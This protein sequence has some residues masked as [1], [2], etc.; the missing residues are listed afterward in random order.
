MSV[1]TNKNK[2]KQATK[3][4]GIPVP[5]WQDGI[6]PDLEM[7]KWQMVENMLMASMRGSVNS[8]FRENT[9]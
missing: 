1:N 5:G 9:Q 7:M 6:W 2:Y 8:I 3:Y 4:L